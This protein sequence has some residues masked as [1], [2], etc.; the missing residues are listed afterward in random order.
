MSKHEREPI[1]HMS[2]MYN[3]PTD[4]PPANTPNASPSKTV[5]AP[6]VRNSLDAA[7]L[8]WTMTTERVKSGRFSAT[9]ATSTSDSGSSTPLSPRGPH[10]ISSASPSNG[11]PIHHWKPTAP[12]DGCSA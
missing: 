6:S 2:D 4:S 5:V 7:A 8:Q 12:K 3:G 1:E 9:S 10:S 11:C